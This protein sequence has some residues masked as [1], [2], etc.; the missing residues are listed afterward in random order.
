M[1]RWEIRNDGWWDDGWWDYAWWDVGWC[2]WVDE[3]MD[4]GF[5]DDAIM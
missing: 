3:I 2:A 5:M 4:H 1:M